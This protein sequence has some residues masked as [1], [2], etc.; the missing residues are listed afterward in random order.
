MFTISQKR[1]KSRDCMPEALTSES[2]KRDEQRFFFMLYVTQ[3]FPLTSSTSSSSLIMSFRSVSLIFYS[4]HKIRDC[5]CAISLCCC[6]D[7][8]RKLIHLDTLR[9]FMCCKNYVHH[10]MCVNMV[11]L[12]CSIWAISVR[13]KFASF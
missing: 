10:A 12:R 13:I 4:L 6:R 5:I 3:N 8:H 7:D 2:I 11:N 9:R 1:G